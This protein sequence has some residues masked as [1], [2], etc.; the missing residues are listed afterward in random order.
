MTNEELTRRIFQDDGYVK[1]SGVEIVEITANSVTVRAEIGEQHLNANGSV[2]GGMLYTVAD[3]A[4]AVLANYLHPITVTQ[5]GN[6]N[7]VRPAIT[8]YVVGTAKET[9]RSGHNTVSEV[10]LY[11]DKGEVC[12]VCH[13]NGF[14]K[15]IDREELKKKYTKK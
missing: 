7:Y 12:C 8:K 14:V 13:F 10:V 4:F 2:Q 1:L 11:D 5:C 3:F 6:I 15:D 9:V